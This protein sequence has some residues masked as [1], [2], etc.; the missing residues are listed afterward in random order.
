MGDPITPCRAAVRPRAARSDGDPSSAWLLEELL[1]E[2]LE[3]GELGYV[4]LSGPPGSGKST[5]LAHIADVLSDREQLEVAEGR[6]LA[7]RTSRGLCVYAGPERIDGPHVA[8]LELAPWGQDELIEL[9]LSF[10]A[11]C[12]ASVLARIGD[13]PWRDALGGLPRVWRPIVERLA[14]DPTLEGLPEALLAHL[15]EELGSP[16]AIE[17]ARR[18]AVQLAVGFTTDPEVVGGGSPLLRAR[19]ELW[20]LLASEE[21]ARRVI[22]GEAV[23]EWQPGRGRGVLEDA[24]RWCAASE[25]ARV[26]LLSSV[27]RSEPLPLVLAAELLHRID[28][29]SLA[30]PLAA[31]SRV[32]PQSVILAGASLPGA[33]LSAIELPDVRA[34]WA[35][36]S[37]ADLSGTDLSR[38]DL[39]RTR[40]AGANLAGARLD[41]AILVHATLAGADLRGARLTDA[42]LRGA[43]LERAC[44]ADAVLHG[45]DLAEARV[46]GLDLLGAELSGARLDA[47]D[48]RSCR[49]DGAILAGARA[50]ECNLESVRLESP[51]WSGADLTGALLTGTA[52]PRARLTGAVLARAGLAE[53]VW[54]GAD[55]RHADFT[56]A[57]FHLGSSR[58]GLVFGAPPGE[59]SRT[60]FYT[61]DAVELARLRPEEFRKAS[62][63]GADLRGAQLLRT[64]LY[65]VDLREARLDP[66]QRAHARAC[67]AILGDD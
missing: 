31:R 51:S 44:L 36:L 10:D 63:R 35:D 41:H 47:L 59:G 65:L 11:A 25:S 22:A 6:A 16:R 61:D 45:A 60:G 5:A 29:A 52:F 7:A 18:G 66:E 38:A 24:A 49:L 30:G 19:G 4:R 67:G 62:L 42:M 40:L 27:E 15:H 20:R 32:L 57:Q 28:P 46:D 55:L 34:A 8:E 33:R 17:H 1:A 58:S 12:C 3:R 26:H 53:V 64:D 9:L 37:R 43:N 50:V 23:D 14:A 56:G 13:S 21:I 48:L 2:L 39:A 54:D